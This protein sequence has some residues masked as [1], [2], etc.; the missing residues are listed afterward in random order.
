MRGRDGK[1]G[2]RSRA[3][4]QLHKVGKWDTMSL[5]CL[6]ESEVLV[7]EK[8]RKLLGETQTSRHKGWR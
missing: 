5:L 2:Q 8:C 7:A 3:V 6:L 4:E 1:S